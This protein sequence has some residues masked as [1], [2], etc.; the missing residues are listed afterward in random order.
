MTSRLKIRDL[1]LIVALH[2]EGTFTQAAK[3]VG[4]T[5]PALSKRLLLIE[6]HGAGH[7]FLT[8]AMTALR[9]PERDGTSS[10]IF[11]RAFIPSIAPFMRRGKL[12]GVSATSSESGHRRTCHPR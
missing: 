4:V 8:G 3:R 1:E 2:E 11:R 7:G 12:S 5:E 10:S 9:S 6:R